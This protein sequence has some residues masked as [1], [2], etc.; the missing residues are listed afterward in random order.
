[1]SDADYQPV[2]DALPEKLPPLTREEAE[3]ATKRIYRKFGKLDNGR[4]RRNYPSH[5]S[6]K[7]GVARRCWISKEE[8]STVDRGWGRLIHD[9]SHDIFGATYPKKKPHD[10]LHVRYEQ[11]IAEY[12][13]E[14]GFLEGKLKPKT[15]PKPTKHKKNLLDIE[16]IEAA[17][18]RWDSKQRRA[19][20]ALT[21]LYKAR[22]EWQRRTGCRLSWPA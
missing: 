15:K 18:K 20:N 19:Q 14:S 8:T 3:K 10:P 12:V 2:R 21:R 11:M 1:M 9:V 16:K 22:R 4:R 13:A 17:I 5:F 7:F 6:G